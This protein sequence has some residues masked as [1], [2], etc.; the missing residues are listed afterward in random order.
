MTAHN[1]QK[2]QKSISSAGFEPAI[3]ASERPQ[4]QALDRAAF[5]FG[6]LQGGRS[7]CNTSLNLL[8][9]DSYMPHYDIQ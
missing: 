8:L 6:V 1:T 9:C 7:K 3:E 5:G 2:R 4:I